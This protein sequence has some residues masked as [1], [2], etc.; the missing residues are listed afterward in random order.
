M[1]K[2]RP[3]RKK[4]R[5]P[6]QRSKTASPAIKPIEQYEHQDKTRLNNPPVG[7][8]TP[9][10]EPARA[11]VKRYAYDPHLDPQLV[12]ASKAEHTSF[13]VPTVSLHVHERIDAR[14]IIEAVR[15]RIEH[16]PQLMQPSLFEQPK[17]NLPLRDPFDRE[18]Q[19][20]AGLEIHPTVA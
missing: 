5:P 6:R 16:G 13:D 2:T 14:T 15:V 11:E 18:F 20:P 17:E 3:A 1:A 19:T 8:V 12:W 10:T 9:E 4:Q 7:L